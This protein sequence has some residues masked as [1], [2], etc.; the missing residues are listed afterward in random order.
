MCL[1]SQVEVE[2][3]QGGL[4]AAVGARELLRV[5]QT[6]YT[7]K[8]ELYKF[9]FVHACIVLDMYRVM[10]FKLHSQLKRYCLQESIISA[11][12]FS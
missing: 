5:V 10:D 1:C 9:K 4:P 6:I 8:S 2:A 11:V 3:E 7:G 12:P